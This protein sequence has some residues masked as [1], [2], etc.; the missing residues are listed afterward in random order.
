MMGCSKACCGGVL[1]VSVLVGVAGAEPPAAPMPIEPRE[2][3]NQALASLQIAVMNPQ[4][5]EDEAARAARKFLEDARAIPGGVASLKEAQK[6]INAIERALENKDAVITDADLA[7]LGPGGVGG[8]VGTVES[9]G[10]IIRF[11]PD[12]AGGAGLPELA[13]ARVALSGGGSMY[14]A[15]EEMS[16]G[17]F[18]AIL[19]KKA[20]VGEMANLGFPGFEAG[21]DPRIGPR[22]WEWGVL[23]AMT[24]RRGV[25]P[26]RAWVSRMGGAAVHEYPTGKEPAPPSEASPM[27]YV[28]PAGALMVARLVGCRLPSAAEW[29]AARGQYA[30][31]VAMAGFNLRDA[32]WKREYE[33]VRGQIWKGRRAQYPDAGSFFV[34]KRD[35]TRR[36][37][38]HEWDDGTIWFRV[39]G[40]GGAQATAV[41]NLVGNVAEYV[42][43]A[44]VTDP[45]PAVAGAVRAYLRNDAVKLEVVGGSALSDP[46]ME[47]DRAQE[48]SVAEAGDGYSDVGFRLAFGMDGLSA[49]GPRQPLAVRLGA[50]LDPLPVLPG[51]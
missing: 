5:P 27:Q 39:V 26:A 36:G 4:T 42:V 32:S 40:D 17:A 11:K 46:A 23:S 13:F 47:V 8:Y 33:W 37:I 49:S 35:E 3:Y 28:S 1:L 21:A 31:G 34:G 48:V 14:I 45:P 20:A 24:G 43:D 10:S 2:Q 51:R 30:A 9:G 25:V 22:T 19:E 6:T 38:A 16:V 29:T 44:P 18:S 50:I 12:G 15:T 41:K 7:R